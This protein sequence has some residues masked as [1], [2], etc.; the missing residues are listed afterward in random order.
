M[1]GRWARGVHALGD[2]VNPVGDAGLCGHEAVIGL[3]GV[4]VLSHGLGDFAERRAGRFL[5]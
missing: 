5:R 1:A 3:G 4:V 2:I